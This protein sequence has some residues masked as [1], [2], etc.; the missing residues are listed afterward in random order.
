MGIDTEDFRIYVIRPTLQKLGITMPAAEQLLL[1]TAAAESSLGAFLKSE[2][3]RTSGI[4][5][6]HGLTHR[7]IWDDYLASRPDLASHVRG[8][9]SQREFLNNPHAE[10]TTNLSYATAIA[11]LAYARQPDFRLPA[12][13]SPEQLAQIWKTCYHLR[14]DMTVDDFLERYE[15]LVEP[16]NAAA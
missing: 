5:R 1:G 3:Q 4:Y 12:N 8:I 11:W 14:D 6:M 7:H 16:S 13:A 9:A 15:L 2:G 10:L